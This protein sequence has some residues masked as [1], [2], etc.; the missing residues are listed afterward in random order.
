MRLMMGHSTLNGNLKLIGKHQTGLCE[1]CGEEEETV[2]HVLFECREYEEERGLMRRKL[3]EQG[4][5][6]LGVR[7]VLSGGGRVKR[8][9]L[10]FLKRVGVYGR[11]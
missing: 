5:E 2:S 11:V 8:V 9:V 7:E 4:I 6:E 1:G 10:G 3:R